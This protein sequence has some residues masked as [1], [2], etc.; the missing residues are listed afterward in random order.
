MDTQSKTAS[1]TA[2]GQA[3]VPEAAE[4]KASGR[5]PDGPLID[6]L[7][8]GDEAAFAHLVRTYHG[9]MVRL[10]QVFVKS[11]AVAEEVVQETWVG[12]LKGLGRFER[13][14]SLKTWL[15]RIL[16]NRARTRAL[17]DGR[18]ISFSDLGGDSE[19]PAVDPARFNRRGRWQQPPASWNASPESHFFASELMSV[20][21]EA[22][23]TLPPA[24]RMVVTLR[25]VEGLSPKDVC[26][27]L[28]ISEANHR[29]LLHRAR[30]R[31]RN[32]IEEHLARSRGQEPC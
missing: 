3:T 20:V 12:V 26:A 8:E 11:R 30:A 29:V 21:Q 4:K 14:C 13:R 32:A 2:T 31:L 19:Q 22:L 16:T 25:D 15:F 17:R 10:A 27:L 9:R 18:T 24:Q 7:L 28:D 5:D 23:A 6:R 1:P